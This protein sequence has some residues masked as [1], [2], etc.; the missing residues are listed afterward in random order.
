MNK[1]ST[2]ESKVEEVAA[3]KMS[4]DK[5]GELQQTNLTLDNVCK[6][7]ETETVTTNGNV[8]FAVREGLLYCQCKLLDGGEENIVDQ[9]VLPVQCCRIVLEVAHNIPMAGHLGKKKTLHRIQQRFYWCS[10][11][12]NVSE[13]CK[14]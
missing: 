5:L 6:L 10:M 11:F 14:S 8:R 12:H 9:L 13:Y 3:T 1:S 4:P 7:T 2:S